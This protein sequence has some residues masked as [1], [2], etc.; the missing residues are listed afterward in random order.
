MHANVRSLKDYRPNVT[1]QNLQPSAA[2]TLPPGA[3][4]PRLL[5][6]VRQAI[7]TRHLSPKTEEAY[8]GWQAI[9]LLP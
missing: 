9:H 8:V 7:R 5:D 1:S 2:I 4:K 6:Q 3:P